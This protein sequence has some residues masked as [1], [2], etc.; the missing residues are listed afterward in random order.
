MHDD[1]RMWV[2]NSP[3]ISAPPPSSH[4]ITLARDISRKRFL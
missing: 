1:S 3:I 2:T 4:T